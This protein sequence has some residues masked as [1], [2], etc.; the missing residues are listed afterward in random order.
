MVDQLDD[1]MQ[2]EQNVNFDEIVGLDKNR[3]NQIKQN[4]K[5]TKNF[6]E[7][8]SKAEKTRKINTS[9]RLF[10]MNDLRVDG[11]NIPDMDD[12]SGWKLTGLQKVVVKHEVKQKG[13]NNFN[14][15]EMAQMGRD[16]S[17]TTQNKN[18]SRGS[19]NGNE[20]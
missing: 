8:S 3:L 9:K 5:I 14:V 10:A 4:L 16:T 18:G 13:S 17:V 12:F 2:L 7:Q 19:S 11:G 6:F 1:G 15:N 20:Q